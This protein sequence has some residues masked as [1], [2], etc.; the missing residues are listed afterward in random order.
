MYK[1]TRPISEDSNE[2]SLSTLIQPSGLT[3]TSDDITNFM[4][5]A[6]LFEGIT[7]ASR[8]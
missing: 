4:R 6:D 7:L 1:V 8:P 3:L 2:F 5:N